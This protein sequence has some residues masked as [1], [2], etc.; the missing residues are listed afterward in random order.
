MTRRKFSSPPPH[1]KLPDNQTLTD[2]YQKDLLTMSEIARRYQSTRQAV[3]AALASLG[4][5]RRRS[6][7]LDP[8][9]LHHLLVECGLTPGEIAKKL[10]VTN[11]RVIKELRRHNIRRPPR[12]VQVALR[13]SRADI[14]RVYKTEGLN[15]TQ[16]ARKLGI[17]RNAFCALLLHHGITY[18]KTKRPNKPVILEDDLRR[19]YVDEKRSTSFIAQLFDCD[20]STV[21]LRLSKMGI[22]L[23]MGLKKVF[24]DDVI[25]RLYVDEERTTAFIAQKLGCHSWTVRSRLKSMGVRLDQG[26][27]E[28]TSSASKA[29]RAE[30]RVRPKVSDDVLRRLYVDEKRTVLF[31]ARTCNCDPSTVAKH[32]I[33]MGITIQRGRREKK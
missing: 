26:R 7:E 27:R 10:R 2:L 16:A 33:K 20:V 23:P 30:R 19:L 13:H 18:R 12:Y 6:P 4:I 21:R 14:E 32:L 1:K 9:V 11:N 29:K 25:R 22:V 8:Y 28:N 15:Q 24:S 17:S 5:P 31:I 3:Q